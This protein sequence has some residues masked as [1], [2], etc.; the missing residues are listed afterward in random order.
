MDFLMK[1]FPLFGFMSMSMGFMDDEPGGTGDE[2]ETPE[3][4]ETPAPETPEQPET[5]ETPEDPEIPENLD[6]KRVYGEN[7]RLSA[8]VQEFRKKISDL[9]GRISRQAPAAPVDILAEAK[10]DPEMARILARRKER[11]AEDDDDQR[12]FLYAAGYRAKGLVES[13]VSPIND[14]MAEST[15]EKTLAEHSKDP[16]IKVIVD[17]WGKEVKEFLIENKVDRKFW[18]N[19]K[20]I[21]NVIGSVVAKHLKELKGDSPKK[22]D[23]EIF[24][25]RGTGEKGGVV[26]G[27][28]S[29]ALREFAKTIGYEESD[30]KDKQLSKLI[31]DAYKA[32]EAA[33][34]E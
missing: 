10:K 27:I 9:E 29:A 24:G 28:D 1:L 12:D 20:F 4:P 5:P 22:I 3:N 26:S 11:F 18:G 7:K 25:E 14:S 16:E 21:Y 32:R 15:L 34:K 31:I 8:E 33:N 2:P 17:K 13:A 30:L 23:R 6:P 19:S